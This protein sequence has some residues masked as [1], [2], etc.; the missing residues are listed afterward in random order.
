VSKELAFDL[1]APKEQ[2]TSM[3]CYVKKEYLFRPF[4]F[5]RKLPDDGGGATRSA[6]LA[7][8]I[9]HS[10]SRTRLHLPYCLKKHNV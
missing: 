6:L 9:H 4:L 7:L 1:T 10:H 3:A 8:A 5:G 2:R